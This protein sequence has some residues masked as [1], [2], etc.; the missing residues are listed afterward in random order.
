MMNGSRL[1]IRRPG[2]RILPILI[3]SAIIIG[4]ALVNSEHVFAR[5]AGQF[6]SNQAAQDSKPEI[7]QLVSGARLEKQLKAG[8]IHLYRIALTPD[9]YLHIIVEQ[10]G[11]DVVVTLFGPEGQ[12]LTVVDS[13]NGNQGPEPIS[14]IAKNGGDYLLEVKQVD[15]GAAPGL[16]E[17]RVEELRA[18]NA[19]DID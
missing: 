12:K 17:V 3:T 4:A 18:A 16:Y 11:I 6:A 9:Q 7:V 8:Q 13:P 15:E 1:K 19:T 2:N 14:V 10:K 5:I